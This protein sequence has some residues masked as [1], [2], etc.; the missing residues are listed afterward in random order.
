MS[1]KQFQLFLLNSPHRQCVPPSNIHRPN[2]PSQNFVNSK[3]FC[4]FWYVQRKDIRKFKECFSTGEVG[5][6]KIMETLRNW[7][8]FKLA[9]QNVHPF[10][11]TM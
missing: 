2:S 11:Y 9:T 4:C 7:T 6:Y 8:E 1:Q 5:V 10:V 3:S